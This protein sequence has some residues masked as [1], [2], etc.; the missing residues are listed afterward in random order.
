MPSAAS[1]YF[2]RLGRRLTED[3]DQLDAEE[4]A[5]TAEASGARPVSECRRGDEA[6]MLG[7]LRS[8]EACSK[9]AGASVQAEF[10]D[11][12]DAIT[13][14]W[15]GRRRIPGIEPGRRI[16]VRGRIGDRDGRKVMFNP[17]YELRGNS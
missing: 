12:T 5:E 13:L 14:V 10:F 7:R 15:I 9:S 17:Y 8:V 16:L 3:I 4:L 6:T 1:G 2:R 11:G